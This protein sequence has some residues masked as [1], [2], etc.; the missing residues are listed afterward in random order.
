[1]RLAS[2]EYLLA[3]YML[4]IVTQAS[5]HKNGMPTIYNIYIIPFIYI[6]YQTIFVHNYQEKHEEKET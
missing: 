1:M 4:I 6:Y 3:V 2:P 5:P